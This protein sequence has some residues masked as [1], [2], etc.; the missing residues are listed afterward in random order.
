MKFPRRESMY[1]LRNV[2]LVIL[3]V[4]CCIT[5]LCSCV[6][7]DSAKSMIGDVVGFGK[8]HD[9]GLISWTVIGEYKNKLIMISTDIIDVVP[10]IPDELTKE[11]F[12]EFVIEWLNTDFYNE[13]FAGSSYRDGLCDLKSIDFP[14]ITDGRGSSNCKV[15][16]MSEDML[17]LFSQEIVKKDIDY[18]VDK[19]GTL[20]AHD[21]AGNTYV[22]RVV[23]LENVKTAK[24]TDYSVENGCITEPDRS[25]SWLVLSE[26]DKLIYIDAT[27]EKKI[28]ESFADRKYAALGIRPV[29][30][31]DYYGN[32]APY[33]K[34]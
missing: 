18:S 20:I 23:S 15:T 30:L 33:S 10:D 2:I 9:K 4:F 22:E 31:V 14:F 12:N 6:K 34:P 13:I 17:Y 28:C 29:I 27:G 8:Y 7:S 19:N 26:K 25:G 1:K 5:L 21:D 16:L 32:Y 24:A 3:A 11:D